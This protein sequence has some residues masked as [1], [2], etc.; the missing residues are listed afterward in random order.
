MDLAFRAITAKAQKLHYLICEFPEGL[1]FPSVLTWLEHLVLRLPGNMAE[2]ARVVQRLTSMQ[3]LQSLTIQSADSVGC[4]PDTE[5]PDL[6][7]GSL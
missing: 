5:L 1:A 4:W 6:D 3:C 2:V 7:V